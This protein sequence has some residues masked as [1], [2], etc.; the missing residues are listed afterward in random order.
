LEPTDP[1]NDCGTIDDGV[2]DATAGNDDPSDAKI[3]RISPHRA[4]ND[5]R[6]LFPKTFDE[7]ATPFQGRQ[8]GHSC[9]RYH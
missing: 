2:E 1:S 6:S 3:A 7:P 5:A 9:H 4:A 8:Q